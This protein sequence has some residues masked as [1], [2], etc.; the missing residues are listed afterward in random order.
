MHQ[1]GRAP[2]HGS[3]PSREAGERPESSKPRPRGSACGIY[4]ERREGTR[5]RTSGVL[6]ERIRNIRGFTVSPRA[7]FRGNLGYVLKYPHRLN[8]AEEDSHAALSS[9][10]YCLAQIP[11][12]GAEYLVYAPRGGTFTVDL[13]AMPDSR[14]PA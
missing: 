14:M 6:I 2:S 13:S 3:P 4:D 8:L 12:V 7:N 10:K 5:D 9:T 11:P 1:E